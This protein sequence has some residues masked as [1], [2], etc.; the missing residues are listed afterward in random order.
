MLA[1]YLPF[2]DDPANPEGDN[3]NL[4][5]KYIVSTPLTFPEYVTPHARDLLK[6]ILV[7][8]PRKR[9]DL[10][11]VAR[12]SWLADYAHVVGF[13]TTSNAAEAPQQ[14]SV[15][16]SKRFQ[17]SHCGRH[18]DIS[19]E[20]PYEQPPPLARSASV[21]EP[22]KTQAPPSAHGGLANKREQINST[23]EKPKTSRDNKRRTVQVEYVAP[24]SQ[25][26]RGEASPPVDATPKARPT[27]RVPVEATN[28]TTDGYQ[29]ASSSRPP[30]SAGGAAA[31][32]QVRPG[33]QPQRSVSDYTAFGTAPAAT[34]RPS[35]GG[36]LGGS[37]MP[38]RGNSYAQPAAATVAP[39]NAEGRF[40]QPQKKNYSISAPYP[41][42][43]PVAM[44]EPSIG[45]PSAQRVQSTQIGPTGGHPKGG[46]KR[47]NTVTE[48]LGRMTSMF[49][50]RQNSYS[51]DPKGSFTSQDS[52][53]QPGEERKQK[54]YPPTSM[55]AAMSNDNSIGS[56]GPRPSTDSRRRPSFSF[57]RKN[58]DDGT[59]TSRRFSLL[60]SSFSKNFGSQR[61][62]MPADG[63]GQRRGSNAGRA[64]N[65]S[66]SGMAF[67]RGNESRSPSQSTMGSNAVPGFYDGQQDSNSRIRHPNAS[68]HS[69]G[70]PGPSSAPAQQTQ[71]NYPDQAPIGDDKFP[72][73]RQ[74][75]PSQAPN[76][77]YGQHSN[78]SQA[79]EQMTPTQS[80]GSQP[81]RAQYPQGMGG[82]PE[83]R[84]G[85]L[86]KH[87]KFEDAYESTGGNKGSSGSSKKV[88]DFFRQM[89]R[90][91]AGK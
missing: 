35:T 91:R 50:G 10:F 67:G 23:A 62:S 4:L 49:G 13:I 86:Q 36:T 70:A 37:R 3:I 34:T 65:G 89:G 24:Q 63:Y 76:R 66:R 30:R 39:T 33:G 73:P 77:P 80:H 47:S 78:D 48:T 88:M 90:R 27:E 18:T 31:P 58:T 26:Q 1:G 44:G 52:Y 7:P 45:Q 20:E 46:H 69:H 42:Q 64:R 12:H 59:K 6:R 56:S 79:S 2:D 57:S 55:P 61:E 5:Y 28:A 84:G 87:R 54:R 71:F 40:S 11:E 15:Y 85:K 82:E 68:T 32:P 38:S 60:P 9:A 14:G 22:T 75:H 43:E 81:S 41:P 8:D 53:S 83:Q 51:Q 25:T 21:R 72:N 29:S 17:S 16:A 74:P 19:V